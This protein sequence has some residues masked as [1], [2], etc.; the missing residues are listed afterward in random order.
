MD[1]DFNAIRNSKDP[2]KKASPSKTKTKAKI[3]LDILNPDQRAAFGKLVEYIRT[4]DDHIHVLKGWAGTGKTFCVS[5]LV[6]YLLKELYSNKRHFRIA[7]TG[8]TNKSVRV[9]KKSSGLNHNRVEFKT[10][11][12]LLG[13]KE[14]ITDDGQQIFV[15]DNWKNDSDL[16]KIS[17]LIID[18]VSMLNDELFEKIIQ[19]RRNLKIICMGDPAQIP[20]VG[21]PDCIPFRE[22][23]LDEYRIKTIQLK[24]IMRQKEG[25]PIIDASVKI[26][27]NLG[28]KSPIVPPVTKLNEDGQGIEFL[29][30]NDESVRR[31]FSSI[32][33]K[34]FKSRIFEVDSEY[35]KIISWRN[36]T[37]TTMNEVVRKVIYGDKSKE[38]RILPGEK[39][40]VNKPILEGE[41]IRFNTNDE[42]TV[43]NYTIMSETHKDGLGSSVLKYYA[44]NVKWVDENGEVCRDKIA[45]LHEESKSEFARIALGFKN[46]ALDMGGKNKSWVDYYNFLRKYADVS[47]AYSITAHKAQGSTYDTVFLMEDDIDVNWKTVEKNRIKYTAYTRASRKI[48]IARAF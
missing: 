37:V 10:I 27:E 4:G 15:N 3:N 40:I 5:L 46:R 7:V 13:L 47:F 12:K 6:N 34:Y 43:D 42:L 41:V 24:T 38:F 16:D 2:S 1:I 32:L 48:Y 17:V 26:R 30:L 33:E 29:N 23:L 35:V 25:N 18:E 39:L 36:S 20:P 11:H 14:R 19:Y 31:G 9:L 45:I 21:R 44:T 22:E 28:F 8:P